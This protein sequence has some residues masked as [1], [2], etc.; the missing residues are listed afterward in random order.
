MN[1]KKYYISI[2]SILSIFLVI[3]AFN[4]NP[5]KQIIK[6]TNKDVIKFSHQVHS[7][8]ECEA[9]HANA[10]EAENLL[11]RLLPAKENCTGCHDVDDSEA[12][13]TCH[14][15]NVQEPLIQ[16][17]SEL[18]FNHKFHIN[19]EMNCDNCHQG[20]SDV[21]YSFESAKV[22][23]SMENCYNCHNDRTEATN[24]CEACHINT[25]NLIPVDHKKSD[26][27]RLHKFEAVK[28]NANCVMCHDNNSCETCHASTKVLTE[29]NK[30]NDFY[31]PFG[32]SNFIDGTKQQQISRVHDLNYRYTHGIDLKGKNGQCQ[33]C[34]EVETFCV[35]CHQ[36]TGGDFALSGIMP[37]SHLK[38]NFVNFPGTDG[39]EHAKLAK[40]DIER[41]ISCH[42]VQ[43]EDPTCVTC[44]STKK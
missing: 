13:N 30:P 29:T 41:C 3:T 9:C 22:N 42:D 7:S 18:I 43:G 20:L 27:V 16:K 11:V 33:T 36:A 34:H 31:Q 15:E 2:V 1:T 25:A 28:V 10:P 35:S 26:Y 19:K 17:E 40:R 23:P 44:H 39:G 38:P 32:S 12:C 24:S 8:V 6:R 37:S 4:S 14:Y 21:D 5:K